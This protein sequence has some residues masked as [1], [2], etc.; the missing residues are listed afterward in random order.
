MRKRKLKG[1]GHEEKIALGLVT[2]M[3]LAGAGLLMFA[4]GGYYSLTLDMVP[5]QLIFTTLIVLKYQKV[6]GTGLL[7]FLVSTFC[8]GFLAE[9]I[10]VNTGWPFGN[11]QYGAV[12][13]IQFL[14]TPLIIGLNWFLLAY[15]SGNVSNMLKT[16]RLMKIVAGVFL[17]VAFDFFMEPVAMKH[18]FWT[19][20]DGFIPFQNYLGWAGVSFFILSLFHLGSWKKE[21]PS[22]LWIFLIMLGFFMVQNIF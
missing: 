2:V 12:L 9:A 19:W 22:A 16:G 18:D 21:N 8:I 17:M 11:Y 6:W 15:L 3:H 10:G 13:G 14:N 1:F 20:S 7:I 4:K 5:I